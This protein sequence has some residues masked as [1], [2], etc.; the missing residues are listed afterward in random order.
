MLEEFLPYF[1]LSSVE[2]AFVV[3]GLLNLLAPT[4]PGPPEL[5]KLRPQYHLP[6]YIRLWSLVSRSKAVD[7]QFLDI[8]SRMAGDSL[9]AQHVPF[10]EFG[11]FTREQSSLVFTAILRMLE[12]PVAE[13]TSAYGENVD[14]FAGLGSLLN[15][16]SGRF[17]DD[18]ARWIVMSLSLKC[19]ENEDSIL[20]QLESLLQAIEIFFHPSNSGEW[21][22]NLSQ[23]TYCLTDFFVM[24]WNH[25]RNGEAEVPEDRRLNDVI[26]TRFVLCLREITFMGIYAKSNIAMDFSLSSLKSLAYLK[27]NLIL[28]GALQRIYP[29]MLESVE[30]HRTAFSLRSLKV[31]SKSI[32]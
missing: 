15:R 29:S 1:S 21:T 14:R 18:I 30:V 31:L 5:E 32:V 24:R 6:T 28:L 22:R 10:S 11:I 19:L 3:I 12:I 26:K 8:F 27:P 17:V 16:N 25:E 20:T 9:E 13:A 23:L 2:R 7:I 4:S